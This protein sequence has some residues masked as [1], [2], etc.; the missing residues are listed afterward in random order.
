M[1][2]EFEGFKR[3][4][5]KPNTIKFG[6]LYTK[7]IEIPFSKEKKRILRVWIPEDYDG[8]KRFPVFY[9][10]DGQNL[11]DRF[12]SAYGDWQLDKRIHEFI[13][14]GHNGVILVGIDCPIDPDV[15]IAE[16]LPFLDDK[17]IMSNKIPYIHDK[18]RP[19]K[20]TCEPYAEIYA[21]YI[22]N[23]VRPLIDETFLTKRDSASRGFGGSSMG[24]LFSFYI[25]NKYPNIFKMC[26]SFSPAFMFY[27]TKY[28]RK[29]IKSISKNDIKIAFYC[30]GKGDLE[31]RILKSCLHWYKYLIKYR[32]PKTS[33]NLIINR[34]YEHNEA[35]W[36]KYVV[37]SFL[38]LFNKK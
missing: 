22:V 26:L 3:Y 13:K 1:S 35:A 18:K 19:Q 34:N 2:F 7:K 6:T 21:D 28:A 14:Q 5:K 31:E 38:F 16:Y 33:L 8:K 15:R 37:P 24:G 17:R 36:T 4:T 29:Y 32:F 20:L 12:S 23:D 10:C 27:K 11:V 9:F 25:V 30:G